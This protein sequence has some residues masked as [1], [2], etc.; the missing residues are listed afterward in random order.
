VTL[1]VLGSTVTVKLEPTSALKNSPSGLEALPAAAGV[2]ESYLIGLPPMSMSILTP[3]IFCSS[4][5][6]P[7]GSCSCGVQ[8]KKNVCSCFCVT[9]LFMTF[10][11]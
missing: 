10:M 2:V 11:V 8:L 4:F 3:R 7:S 1:Y 6:L 9:S 5:H